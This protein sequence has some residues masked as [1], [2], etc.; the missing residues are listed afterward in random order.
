MYFILQAPVY[1]F[2]SITVTCIH[3]TWGLQY[4]S[5]QE[6]VQAERVSKLVTLID[7]LNDWNSWSEILWNYIMYVETNKYK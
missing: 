1:I 6:M 5:N 7:E 4:S 2:Y 3:C